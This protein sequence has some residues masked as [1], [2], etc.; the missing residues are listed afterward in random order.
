MV[1][2][3]WLPRGAVLRPPP[4]AERR[5]TAAGPDLYRRPM[6]PSTA[7]GEL[8]DER[9]FP[10]PPPNPSVLTT[11]TL[12][13]Q[14]SSARRTTGIIGGHV[15]MGSGRALLC[16]LGTDAFISILKNDSQHPVGERVQA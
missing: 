6:S 11:Y 5:N 2:M 7:T 13:A 15:I 16:P 12:A 8:V 3:P 4:P 1:L 14:Y 9:T 10:P